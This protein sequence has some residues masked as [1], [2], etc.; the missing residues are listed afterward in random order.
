MSEPKEIPLNELPRWSVWPARLLGNEPFKAQVRTTDKVADEYGKDKWQA[1]LDAFTE[2]G[3][4]LEAPELRR[5]YYARDGGAQRAAVYR[6]K[7]V[8]AYA[9]EI[10]DWY[11]DL[12]AEW[13]QPSIAKART[14]VELGAGFGQVL[15]ALR[16]RFPGKLWRGGEYTDSAVELASRL[17]APH[18]DIS[19]EHVNFYDKS[20]AVIEKAEGPIVVYTSQALEQIPDCS[21]VIETLGKYRDKIAAVFHLEPAFG[22][23]DGETVLGLMRRRYLEINDYNRNLVDVLKAHPDVRILRMEKDVIGWNA[24]NS[25]GMIHWEFN[26]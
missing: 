9:P 5:Q 13:M 3:G 1:A 23:Q 17:Y 16:Q 18:P 7:I 24:F 11:D 20:Y 10:S 22:L 14:V 19:V 6:G 2:S 4:K 8:A 12:F 21:G 26:R 15:W 25:L